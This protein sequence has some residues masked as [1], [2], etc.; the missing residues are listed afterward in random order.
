MI[1]VAEDAKMAI[2]GIWRQEYVG[3]WQLSRLSQLSED[4]NGVLMLQ[5]Q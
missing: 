4:E 3:E 1:V 2:L 5:E